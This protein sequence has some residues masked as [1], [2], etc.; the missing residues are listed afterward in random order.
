METV[1][2]DKRDYDRLTGKLAALETELGQARK[3]L[4]APPKVGWWRRLWG[5]R[6]KAAVVALVVAFLIGCTTFGDIRK[7]EPV[8][9]VFVIDGSPQKLANCASYELSDL[10]NSTLIEKQ[11]AYY[12][13]VGYKGFGYPYDLGEVVF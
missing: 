8:K 4:E 10:F 13:L 7:S 6:A 11:G 1:T 2:V 12:I 5:M 9:N 3:F